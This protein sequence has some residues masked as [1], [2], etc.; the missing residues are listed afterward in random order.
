MGCCEMFNIVPNFSSF[1]H[2]LTSL[3]AEWQL[4]LFYK[5]KPY[6]I[7][8]HVRHALTAKFANQW[9]GRLS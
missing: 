3:K 7:C 2:K 8:L 5:T 1:C 4:Q 9:V 6:L